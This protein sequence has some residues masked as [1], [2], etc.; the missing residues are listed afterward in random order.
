M[1]KL[2]KVSAGEPDVAPR[3]RINQEIDHSLTSALTEVS[4]LNCTYLGSTSFLSVFRETQPGLSPNPIPHAV[5]QGRWSHEHTFLAS[6]LAWL[7]SA[8]QLYEE[9]IIGHYERTPTAIIPL[10]LIL[11]PLKMAR[12]YLETNGWGKD[13]QHEEIY[14]KITRNTA[15]PFPTLRSSSSPWDFYTM[16]TGANLRWEFIGIIFAFAGLGALSGEG[17]LFKINGQGSMSANVFAEEM[18][19]ASAICIDICKQLDKV[20]DL[21]IWLYLTHGA[22]AADFFGE[23]STKFMELRVLGQS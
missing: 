7:L 14:S 23:T 9:L 13:L 20:N 19:A 11:Q 3:T 15:R 4:T 18:T 16:L 12:T 6:R 5:L 2:S 22:L 21:M 1:T 8:F 17:N 10:Q